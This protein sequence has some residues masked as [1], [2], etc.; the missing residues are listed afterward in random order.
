MLYTTPKERE[1]IITEADA[2][3]KHIMNKILTNNW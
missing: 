2:K 3:E 1:K